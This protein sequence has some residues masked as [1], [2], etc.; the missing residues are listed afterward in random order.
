MKPAKKE[1]DVVY[2]GIDEPVSVR[3]DILEASKSLVRVLKGQHGLKETRTTKHKLI[4]DLRNKVTEI[5]QLV[6]E[7]RQ[8]LPKM[9]MKLPE[10]KEAK[11]PKPKIAAA[12]T[13]PASIPRPRVEAHIDKFERE[14]RDIEEKLKSL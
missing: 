9:G 14:I 11:A 7:A 3:R 6:A 4:E 8:M 2:V 10:E 5:G 12:K 13:K 1:E